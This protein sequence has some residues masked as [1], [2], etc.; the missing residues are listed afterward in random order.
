[1]FVFDPSKRGHVFLRFRTATVPAASVGSQL[2]WFCVI[3][4]LLLYF[5]AGKLGLAIIWGGIFLF[6]LAVLFPLITLPMEFNAGS[7]ARQMLRSAGI[8]SVKEYES[9]SADPSVAALIHVASFF[10]ALAQLKYFILLAGGL[11]RRW[12]FLSECQQRESK[13]A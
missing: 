8:V 11:G 9:A 2:G 4:G 10:Q 5:L 7:R 3:G 1:M 6:A 12:P 13:N